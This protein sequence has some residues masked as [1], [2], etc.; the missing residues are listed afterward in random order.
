M[1]QLL[2]VFLLFALC[3]TLSAQTYGN[4][5]IDFSQQ[6]FKIKIAKNGLFRIPFSTLSNAG[7]PLGSINGNNFQV[8]HMGQEIPIYV[9]TNGLL[10]SSDFIEF[11]GEKNDGTL[12][13][14]LYPD[15]TWQPYIFRSLFTDSS[16]YFLTWNGLAA[17]NRM[18]LT[19]NDISSPP[20]K[21]NYFIHEVLSY[22]TDEYSP[23][24][25]YVTSGESVYSSQYELGEG[26]VGGGFAIPSGYYP[27]SK[28]YSLTTKNIYLSGPNANVTTRILGASSYPHHL[29]IDVE[30]VNFIDDNYFGY[31][32]QN[33][34]FPVPLAT[35]QPV[36]NL[37]FTAL[38]SGVYNK[39]YVCYIKI[40]YAHTFNFDNQS[41]FLFN[42][43][44]DASN[45]KYLEITNF[46]NLSTTP[47]LYDLTNQLRM[48]GITQSG[49]LK[50]H[51]P[52][53]ASDRKLF[54]S[55]QS[56]ADI[57]SITTLYPI[58]FV[59]YSQPV[60]QGDYI[61]I[62]H[63]SLINDTMGNNYVQQ[64]ADYR[65]ITGYNSII[66][67]ISQLYDQFAYGIHQHPISIH[68]F[69]EYVLAN[70]S[71]NPGHLFIIGKG[72]EYTYLPGYYNQSLVPTFGSPASDN[73]LS[74]P[75]GTN[76]YTP[77]IATGRL[78]A[79]TPDDVRI[80]LNKI[81]AHEA[82]FNLPQTITD[83]A[84]MK[85]II[86]LGGGNTG[87]QQE[88]FKNYL[89]GYKTIIEDTLYGGNVHSFFKTSTDPIQIAESKI[90]DSLITSGI[91]LMTFFGH[92]TSNSFDYS[93]DD[94]KSFNN[95]GKYPLIISNACYTGTLHQP[96]ISISEEFVLIED[97]G[98][99]GF[100]STS[101]LGTTLALN[102]YTSNFYKSLG[103]T[104]YNQSLGI[105]IQNTVTTI[106]NSFSNA[107]NRM[108]CEQMN[109]HGDPGILLNT[110]TRPDYVLEENMVSFNPAIVFSSDETFEIDITIT[111]L[112]KAV[113]DSFY[114]DIIREFPDGTELP[115]YKEKMLSTK[116]QDNIIVT[117]QTDPFNSF[118]LNRFTITIDGDNDIDEIDEFNN[119]VVKELFI[120]TDK[121]IPVYPYDFSIVSSTPITLKASTGTVLADL[122]QYIFEI[123]TTEY[124]NSSIKQ[125]VIISQFGGVLKWTPTIPWYDST[126]YYWRT[127]IDSQYN[128]EYNWS[129]SSFIYIN[130]SSSGWNQSHYFQ[131]LKNDYTN[132]QLSNNR[133]FTFVDNIKEIRIVNGFSTFR[134][135]PLHWSETAAYYLNGTKKHNW[136]CGSYTWDGWYIVVIDPVTGIPW[137]S[138][139]GFGPYN[140][141]NCKTYNFEIFLFDYTASAQ[142]GMKKLLETV[143]NGH[144][145][146]SYSLQLSNPST[147]SDSLYIAFENI[148]ATKIR[149]LPDNTIYAIFTQKGN[150]AFPVTEIVGDS[151]SL[152][153]IIDTTMTFLTDW[154]TGYFESTV[155]GP[156]KDWKSLHWKSH[157]IDSIPTD[158]VS[159][160]IIGI[161]VDQSETVLASGITANDTSISFINPSIYPYIKLKYNTSDD[162]LKTPTQLDYWRVLFDELPDAALNPSIQYSFIDD[163]LQQGNTLSFSIAIENVSNT[164]MDSLLIKYQ[165]TDN[166][167]VK[168]TITYPRQDSLRINDTLITSLNI[169][170]IAYPK[171]NYFLIEANPNADQPEMFHFN[172]IALIP[173]Y[174]IGDNANPLLDVTF[175]GVHILDGDIV[176]AKPEILITLKDENQYLALDDT[177]LFNIF[178]K[179]PTNQL[180]RVS[181]SNP[182]V[183]FIP[184]SIESNKKSS[185]SS[186]NKATIQFNPTLLEDG[187]YQLIVQGQDK[188]G[189]TSGKLDYKINF[190]VINKPSITNVLNYPNPFTT[191]TKFVFT[192]TGS[193]VP[194]Y[195][196]IQIMTITGRIIREIMLDEL[197]PLHIGRNIT[198]YSWNGT[199]EFGD[200]LANGLYL[201]RVVVSIDGQ[202]QMDLRETGADKY[203]ESG[204][205]KMYIAR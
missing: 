110:H 109:L 101:S 152:D 86:H 159:V 185:S 87:N 141:Y 150:L 105:G 97:K 205:G 133:K 72:L 169:S 23:G 116:F 191:S 51:L 183:T 31:I 70:W 88:Q 53:S 77:R 202:Q 144:Y 127:S 59:D 61:I 184:A 84:W 46:N 104:K 188:S 4:E 180:N 55:S 35:L 124:F 65:N 36:T 115:I 82:N 18:V 29:T 165:I 49:I 123:D 3:N 74:A 92:G 45:S 167:N 9:T 198:Q 90:L 38:N 1:R 83:K 142:S 75:I 189:N 13:N 145:I 186:N 94:P 117:V 98:A 193:E 126:V 179:D 139:P 20:P 172:N 37:T 200:R 130:N 156:V 146:L 79:Q 58:S 15:S 10:G 154:G 54:L 182:N 128:G 71:P 44:G 43:K 166:A 112:G 155:I 136:K 34:T 196:K 131:Y 95:Y 24:L 187:K 201:Y 138:E 91:S 174:V 96:S 17:N 33:Y 7:I 162:S 60:N 113:G 171:N 27:S 6:Y 42:T 19:T 170:S 93:V 73:L 47:I 114:L 102:N 147:W 11:Y 52:V 40:E 192:L 121:I 26:Y 161:K 107:F 140:N 204:F 8:F 64:Y 120:F 197:G 50:F 164:N 56:L 175:D 132:I 195:F 21:E 143:P 78:S 168:H 28:I 62:S 163:T 137:Q 122:K 30:G 80:Y 178:L 100:L 173:F 81:K 157:S 89:N 148:G 194:V 66:C 48:D 57:P 32:I 2:S 125:T 5:W 135:G 190:E 119:Y 25:E 68:H 153:Y 99:I 160:D 103:Q 85:K 129:N 106:N 22:Y 41:T 203:F 134:G 177:A 12:D 76:T 108:I 181:F 16:A 158:Q 39:N 67:D 149:S 199:D 151:A 63:S 176:S 69:I 14:K 111:N 118:G